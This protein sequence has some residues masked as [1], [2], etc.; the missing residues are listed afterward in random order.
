MSQAKAYR[1]LLVHVPA[2]LHPDTAELVITFAGALAGKLNLSEIKHGFSNGWKTMDWREECLRQLV[3]H[4]EKG[5]PL[6]VAAYAAFCWAR[7]W[8]TTDAMPGRVEVGLPDLLCTVAGAAAAGAAAAQALGLHGHGAAI[9]IPSLE[10][11]AET[12]L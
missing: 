1:T 11:D 9:P 2:D 5:D 4:I 8:L 12:R 3:L 7:G 10:E 6:D